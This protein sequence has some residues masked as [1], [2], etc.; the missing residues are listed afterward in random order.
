ME[1]C[2]AKQVSKQHFTFTE[3]A[4]H[5]VDLENTSLVKLTYAK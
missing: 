2:F 3:K 1:S 4:A 5:E